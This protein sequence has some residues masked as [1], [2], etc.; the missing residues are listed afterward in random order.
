MTEQEK[1]LVKKIS[2]FIIIK[3][4]DSET[5]E[6]G[7]G[8][9]AHFMNIPIDMIRTAAIKVCQYLIDNKKVED[10]DVLDNQ[11]FDVMLKRRPA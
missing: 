9:V 11:A 10:I 6:V 2:D 3:A 5:N 8:S 4:M 7:Y 1:Q